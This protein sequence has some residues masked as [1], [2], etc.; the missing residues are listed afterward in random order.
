MSLYGINGQR[1]FSLYPN[2]F[3]PE[4]TRVCC[5]S[6]DLCIDQDGTTKIDYNITVVETHFIITDV[7]NIF[8][9]LTQSS[10][11]C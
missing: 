2:G 10:A 11:A 4:S 3:L 7:S 5:S 1:S 6:F 9:S 8:L